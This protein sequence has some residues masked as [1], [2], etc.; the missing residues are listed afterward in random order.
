MLQWKGWIANRALIIVGTLLAIQILNQLDSWKTRSH[1]Y[2]HAYLRKDM[3]NADLQ[4]VPISKPSEIAII[5]L[6]GGVLPNGSPPPHTQ[7]RIAKAIELFHKFDNQPTIITLSGGTPHKPNPVDSKGFPI[8]E[9]SSAAKMLIEM[10]I[11][12]QKVY[13]ENFSLDTVGNVRILSV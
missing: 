7:L 11:P 1:H 13:E 2:N 8:W 3:A 5:V 6:G 9:A 10:G 4:H 12:S